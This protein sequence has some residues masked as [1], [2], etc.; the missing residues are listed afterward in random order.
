MEKGSS[1]GSPQRKGREDE[2]NVQFS[3]E[4]RAMD[5]RVRDR[6]SQN[7]SEE[8]GNELTCLII[9]TTSAAGVRLIE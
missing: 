9:S 1:R 7:F 3:P 2:A 4:T 5:L 6:I 8:E